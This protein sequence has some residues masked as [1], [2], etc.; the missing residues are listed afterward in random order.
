MKRRVS[1]Q[2]VG[3]IVAPATLVS[4]VL[5]MILAGLLSCG[6]GPANA[7]QRE[8]V[9]SRRLTPLSDGESPFVAVAER[10]IPSVVNVS[11]ERRVRVSGWGPP[12]GG[13]FEELFR[14]F[15]PGEPGLPLE[16]ERSALG[17]GVIITEAGHIVTN[18]HVVAD[19]DRITVR[20]SDGTEFAGDEVRVIGRDPQTDL[21]VIKIDAGRKL[22]AITFGQAEDIRVGDWA[23]AVGNP[24]GLQGTVTV[25]VIS[26]TGRSGLPLR[27]G[28]SYQDFV[29]TD[30]SINPGNSGGA[31][32]NI[33]GE[34][35]GVNTAIRSPV[36]ANVG[37]GFA[38]PVDMVM[39]VTG[40]LVEH[41]RVTRGYLGIRPQPVTDAI[42]RAMNLKS[43]AGVL[44]SEVI[45]G[46]PAE[47]AG[48]K[49]GDVIIEVGGK[50]A[51]DVEQ[52]RRMVAEYAPGS[53]VEFK[54]IRDG[55]EQ[56][57]RIR[58]AEFPDEEVSAAPTDREPESRHFG[59]SVRAPGPAERAAGLTGAVV[60]SVEPGS[61]A[62][63]AGI[64]PGDIVLELGGR[65]VR[66][67]REFE[68]E[69]RRQEAAGQ[70]VLV[71]VQRDGRT[72]FLALEPK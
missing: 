56:R 14:R 21:A 51:R 58:L 52:F 38:V 1:L 68:T 54:L 24:F 33:R 4:F 13:P 16:Q 67:V 25:G 60:E 47:K 48:I 61:A 66:G 34:L 49:A 7:E 43:T 18:N 17:S 3:A 2:L 57:K 15:F 59:M 27:E 36:G 41:G 5:G 8:P 44:V 31:L 50:A 28:P 71:R 10:V 42:R 32:V 37:I 65:P 70:A 53:T 23:I 6:F 29:Q 46:Q 20:L 72:L 40:Q 11:V 19:Y 55:R 64:L 9:D 35:I 62:A 30:A 39:S 69:A 12:P 45:E 26:A 22:P 63:E